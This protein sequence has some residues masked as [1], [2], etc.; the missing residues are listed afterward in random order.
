M[1]VALIHDSLE[2]NVD[3]SISSALVVEDDRLNRQCLVR[4]L[5]QIGVPA[6][7]ASTVA[8][9]LEKLGLDPWLVLLDMD[10][11]DGSGSEILRRIRTTQ[12]P[13]KVCV[14]TGS[15]LPDAVEKLNELQPDAVFLKPY[16]IDELLH[17]VRDAREV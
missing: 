2:D 3:S 4:L 5:E 12:M 10:L 7:S 14:L 11:P 15:C 1:S 16:Q 17:W 9:G 13:T 8:T 6:D